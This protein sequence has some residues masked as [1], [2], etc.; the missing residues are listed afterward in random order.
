MNWIDLFLNKV[1]MYSL[2]LYYLIALIAVAVVLSFFG[3][4]PYNPWT[5]LLATSVLYGTSKIVNPVFGRLFKVRPNFESSAITGLILALIFG[6]TIALGHIWKLGV[7]AAVAM[8]SKYVIIFQKRHIFNPAAFAA[9]V[10]AALLSVG[11]SWW[12]GN[13]F[14]LPAVAIGGFLFLRKARWFHLSLSFLITY[15]V[16]H[17]A[18]YFYSGQ[19]GNIMQ[20]LT[21]TL[22]NSP[23]LFFSFVMLTEPLTQPSGKRSRILFGAGVALLASLLPTM[24]DVYYGLELSLI[25]GNIIFLLL[26]GNTRRFLHLV[27]KTSVAANTTAFA[28]ASEKKLAFQPGQFLLWSLPHTKTDLRGHRRYF[29]IASSP[30]EENISLVT[31]FAEKSSTFKK[32]LWE[33]PPE[34]TIMASSLDGDFVL[35]K[36]RQQKCVFIAGGV[37]IVPFRSMVKFLLDTKQKQP[38]TLLYSNNTAEEICFKEI[39]DQAE[40]NLGMKTVYTL[41]NMDQVP[42]DWRGKT[43][44]IDGPVI[45][46]E[47]KEYRNALYY[48]SGPDSFVRAME[49]A[50]K[51]IGIP[52]RNIKTD[53]FP[54]YA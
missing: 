28:F 39:F 52:S 46:E 43:G 24:F 54:G 20:Y 18:L 32:A 35:P 50:L 38:I 27:K 34:E 45:Q 49:K 19:G 48:V 10:S 51:G 4:L 33:L 25:I 12:V 31:K 26:F 8:L 3:V 11:A 17:I 14:M 6:P 7:I 5:M 2:M 16:A 40:K 30:T 21:S 29:S 41:T 42:T 23:I 13:I 15:F 53:Y 44:Y 47:V 22:L 1:T 36:D 9:V 37:G